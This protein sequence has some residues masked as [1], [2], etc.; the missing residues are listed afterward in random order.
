MDTQVCKTSGN[1]IHGEEYVPSSVSHLR[2]ICRPFTVSGFV[3]SIIV[4]AF[5]R[6]PF[7]GFSH[8]IKEN[9]KRVY[10]LLAN[11][12]P[13]APIITEAFRMGVKASLFH[14]LPSRVGIGQ[15]VSVFGTCLQSQATARF[16]L[17]TCK[18]IA[19]GNNLFSALAA[20][21]ELLADLSRRATIW[22]SG[23]YGKP[24]KLP[25]DN[26]FSV[27]HKLVLPRGVQ[28]LRGI[29]SLTACMREAT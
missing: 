7:W 5:N 12:Y 17:P 6:H 13:P 8:V 18:I 1:A 10:P 14:A 3:I 23:N 29:F 9:F 16:G 4:D 21:K 15:A 25:P 27:S 24:C 28:D 2:G 22:R 20:T 11:G 19:L 26:G